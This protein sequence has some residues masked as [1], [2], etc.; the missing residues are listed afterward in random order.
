ML[1]HCKTLVKHLEALIKHAKL[2]KHHETLIKP[3]ET[4]VILIKHCD[5]H[6]I[7]KHF[8]APMRATIGAAIAMLGLSISAPGVVF[9][10][11]SAIT[12]VVNSA[13]V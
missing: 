3:L 9:P 4:L 11:T 10:A 13:D 1:K 6:N 12:V 7:V 2:I 5:T 8:G